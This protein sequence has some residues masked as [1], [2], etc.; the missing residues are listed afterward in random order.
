MSPYMKPQL[1]SSHLE[2]RTGLLFKEAYLEIE[3]VPEPS[4]TLPGKV[5]WAF[6]LAY[7]YP[8]KGPL[9]IFIRRKLGV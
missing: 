6:S 2:V 7:R 5:V 1:E 4:L 3:T 9:V 8:G